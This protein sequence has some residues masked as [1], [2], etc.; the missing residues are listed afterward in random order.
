MEEVKTKRKYEVKN[1]RYTYKEV[2]IYEDFVTSLLKDNDNYFAEFTDYWDVTRTVYCVS[3]KNLQ[4][5][6]RNKEDLFDELINKTTWR[7]G[8]IKTPHVIKGEKIKYQR[9]LVA[10][11]DDVNTLIHDYKEG[12]KITEKV[13]D[14]KTWKLIMKTLNEKIQDSIIEGECYKILGLGSIRLHVIER[15][16]N[17]KN[18]YKYKFFPEFDDYT[19]LKWRKHTPVKN[20]QAYKLRPVKGAHDDASFN[21]RIHNTIKK[22]PELKGIYPYISRESMKRIKETK[23]IKNVL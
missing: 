7:R 19:L 16:Y 3:P 9:S 23:S 14:F 17:A 10:K 11:L 1:K 8:N 4:E 21:E 15:T 2:E 13:I 6:K 5:L 12:K 18:N 22:R 20:I